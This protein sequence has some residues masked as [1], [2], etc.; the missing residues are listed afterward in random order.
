MTDSADR[1]HADTKLGGAAWKVFDT[2]V[3]LG[4]SCSPSD[5]SDFGYDTHP[6]MRAQ[7]RSL[8]EAISSKALLTTP[9]SA[10]KRLALSRA[11]G[12][13]LTRELATKSSCRAV[14]RRGTFWSGSVLPPDLI[15]AGRA[16]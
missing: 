10:E 11:V 15:G 5:Y 6:P 3:S 8:E 13:W 16:A 9:T 14:A 2:L 4:G 7:V 1:Y 12:L